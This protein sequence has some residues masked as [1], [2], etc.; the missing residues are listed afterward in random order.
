MEQTAPH[1]F[2][3]LE[4]AY[5]G[6][7]CIMYSILHYSFAENI[8]IRIVLPGYSHLQHSR[9]KTALPNPTNVIIM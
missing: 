6:T 3:A 2:E 9:K 7:T 8:I 5:S 4:T 1:T